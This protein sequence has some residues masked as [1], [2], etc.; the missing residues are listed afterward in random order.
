MQM[1]NNYESTKACWFLSHPCARCVRAF[2]AFCSLGASSR[3]SLAL[4]LLFL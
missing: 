3:K 4:A 1:P 2:G